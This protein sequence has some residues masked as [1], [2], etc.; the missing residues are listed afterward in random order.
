MARPEK[1]LSARTVATLVKPGMHS[2]GGGL[3][4][5]IDEKGRKS[6]IFR[7]RFG[8]K[9]RDMG[10][11]SVSD[12]SLVE[13]RAVRDSARAALWQGSD[14]IQV[15]LNAPGSSEGLIP[16]FGTIAD[17]YVETHRKTWRNEK[18]G[19]QW[20]MTLKEYCGVIRDKPVNIVSTADVLQVLKP[21]WQTVPETAARLRGRIENVLDAARALGHIGESVANPARWKGHLDK[22]LPKRQRLSRGHHPA[23]PWSEVPAFVA[24]MRRENSISAR[25]LEFVIL[26]AARSGEVRLAEIAEFDLDEKIWTVPA[27]RMKAGREH[28]VPLTGRAVEI[29]CELRSAFPDAKYVFPGVYANRPI[30][31]MTLLGY[32]RK[33]KLPFVVHGFRSSFADWRREA[34]S[35]NREIGEAALAHVIG[36]E[37]EAAYSRGD[38]LAKRRELMEAWGLF[39][40]E[41]NQGQVVAFPRRRAAP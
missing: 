12:I 13:A 14:P 24:G 9:R 10:L 39:L 41:P 15:R 28:R 35:F 38:V 27:E 7:Y 37:T 40:S 18:H 3:Y 17:A 26:T 11:G 30:S 20:A 4:L 2:D 25:A 23:M 5:R 8:E 32:L 31:D 19:D 34:T 16:T 21:L 22:L 36:D 1:L 29:V 33:R 6:W